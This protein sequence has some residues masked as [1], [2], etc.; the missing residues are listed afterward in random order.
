MLFNSWKLKTIA[1]SLCV[2]SGLA[3][4]NQ[5]RKP[6]EVT[7]KEKQV[8]ALSVDNDLFVP[9]TTDRDFTAGFALTYTG[10]AGRKYWR[11]LDNLVG[12]LDNWLGTNPAQS[13]R[14]L[15]PSIEFGGYGFTPDKIDSKQV[16]SN[17]RPYASLIY[18]SAS[19]AYHS[20]DGKNAWTTS[21]TVAALGL[22]IFEAGQ[23][24]V[25]K[26]IGS[27]QAVG[28]DHQVSEGGELTFRYQ[29]AY[30]NYWQI[31]SHS[32]QY[33]TTY[34][35]S[36]GYLTEAG[37]AIS[38]RQGRIAS[39]DYRF[40]PELVSYGE[41]AN[42]A[43]ASPFAGTENYFWGG[44]AL[45]ARAYNAFLQGQFRSSSHTLGGSELRPLLAEA[46]AGY[47]RSLDQDIKVSYVIRAQSSEIRHGKGD[48]GLLWGGFVL[49]KSL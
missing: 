48:R 11:S 4:A 45:K 42:E 17:D 12:T 28:W 36:V 33:K 29:S 22:S 27:E 13:E 10:H 5:D 3:A 25:H 34:F 43:A 49:S 19:R 16:Q 18:L 39:P 14:R 21:L 38:T 37:I 23:N 26:L 41:R 35:G 32:V 9:T 44:I 8:I 47:T 46:W 31:N 20:A 24:R 30:H 1:T 2:I 15:T 7:A 6:P 40:N